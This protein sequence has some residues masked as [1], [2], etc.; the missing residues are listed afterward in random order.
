MNGA[1]NRISDPLVV[2][3][4]DDLCRR[5]GM[6]DLLKCRLRNLSIGLALGSEEFVSCIQRSVG[7]NRMPKQILLGGTGLFGTRSLSP[8]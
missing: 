1:G 3:E 2:A 6:I 8:P 5:I 4:I 7:R